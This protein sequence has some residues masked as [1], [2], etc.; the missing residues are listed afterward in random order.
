[1]SLTPLE[2][3]VKCYW[4]RIGQFTKEWKEEADL[5]SRAT[6]MLFMLKAVN[7]RQAW[8]TKNGTADLI[9]CYNGRFIAIECKD[10]EGEPTIQ[11]LNFIAEVLAAGGRAAVC[12]TLESI[13]NLLTTDGKIL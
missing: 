11:Q 9:V 7:V 1:M 6:D 4:T 5:L 10:D 2:S 13:F 3:S 8:A 12:R